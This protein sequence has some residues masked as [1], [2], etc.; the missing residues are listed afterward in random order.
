MTQRLTFLSS[1]VVIAVAASALVPDM[2]FHTPVGTDD[3]LPLLATLVGASVLLLRPLPDPGPMVMTL[4]ALALLA[5]CVNVLV[6]EHLLFRAL[7]RGPARILM[8]LVFVLGYSSVVEGMNA[9]R[10]LVACG[11]CAVI[12]AIFG[13]GAF[14]FN[15][16][17]PWYVG[18]YFTREPS[19][20]LAGSGLGRIVGTFNTSNGQGMNFASAYLMIFVP[21][22]FAL[23]RTAKGR[24]RWG[25]YLATGLVAAVMLATYTRMSIVALFGGVVVALALA[26]HLKMI[27]GAGAVGLF[28]LLMTPGLAQRFLDKND[29]VSLYAAALDAAFESPWV[30][31]GD[32]NYL[33]F[34]F[35]TFP[36]FVRTWF[37]TLP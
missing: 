21:V 31:H 10:A 9:R 1:L 36:S 34:I 37:S 22:L 30:G 33:E 19:Q 7:V 25:W 35:D 5:L 13:L 32:I 29:R 3:V 16:K 20:S 11:V 28:G 6:P 4:I 14:I 27:L 17:G 23:A 24:A 15:Y 18:V 8:Y 2:G 26:G 12:E